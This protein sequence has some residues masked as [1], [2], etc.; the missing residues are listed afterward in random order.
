MCS[1]DKS[2]LIDFLREFP[3]DYICKIGNCPNDFDSLI[4]SNVGISLREPKNQNNLLCHFYVTNSDILSIKNI[5]LEGR[6]FNENM[7]LIEMASF[8]CTLSI[9]SYILC[10]FIRRLDAIKGQLNFIEVIFCLLSILAFNGKPNYKLELE[11]IA[12][13]KNILNKYYIVQFA[14]L[15]II[16]LLS[17]I[18]FCNYYKSDLLLDHNKIDYIFCSYYF[19][20]VIEH[21]MSSIFFFNY[22]SFNKISPVFNFFF[23]FFILILV[24]YIV[25]L[26]T[27]NRSNY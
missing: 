26:I 2:L 24:L 19:I 9:N 10:C 23:M 18:I 12:K 27:L 1:I 4:S 6:V 3:N 16:K 20:L 17:I 15:L 25:K 7:I 21:I 14:G 22:I 5:I 11:P 13:N 8:F